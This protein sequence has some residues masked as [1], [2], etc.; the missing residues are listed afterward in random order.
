[1]VTVDALPDRQR[2]QVSEIIRGICAQANCCT[3]FTFRSGRSGNT[4]SFCA[5]TR[6][7]HAHFY[8]FVYIDVMNPV[9]LF[10]DIGAYSIFGSIILE[11]VNLLLA[12]C[13]A[14]IVCAYTSISTKERFIYQHRYKS[15]NTLNRAL[16]LTKCREPHLRRHALHLR[17]YPP[18]HKLALPHSIHYPTTP[19]IW[20]SRARSRTSFAM[21]G[22]G[23]D[24]P[25]P[26]ASRRMRRSPSSRTYWRMKSSWW[27]LS[28][29]S[30]KDERC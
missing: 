1:M 30:L 22:L 23:G 14:S 9:N 8:A 10:Y 13:A 11:A 27:S 3:M 6:K 26:V 15:I 19:Q 24:N 21:P 16:P 17:N 2:G 18:R 20:T 25:W 29:K 7:R 12:T 5:R 28:R 4:R